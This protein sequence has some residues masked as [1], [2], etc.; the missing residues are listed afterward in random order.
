MLGIF[1]SDEFN[2]FALY[3]VSLCTKIMKNLVKKWEKEEFC[4][5]HEHAR[6]E[7]RRTKIG[8]AP[9]FRNYSY[10]EKRSL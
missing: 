1:P 9:F 6:F 2:I 10:P 7:A 4:Q 5:L 8:G 3:L